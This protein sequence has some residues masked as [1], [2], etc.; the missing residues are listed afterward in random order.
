[1]L[2]VPVVDAN[3]KPLMPT[4]ANRAA[5]C[6]IAGCG[7]KCVAKGLCDTH[8]RRLRKHGS[9][10]PTRVVCALPNPSGLCLCGCGQLAPIAAKT[11]LKQQAIKGY[12]QRFVHGHRSRLPQSRNKFAKRN[13]LARTHGMRATPEYQAWSQAKDRCTN[14]RSHAWEN[15]GGRGIKF[16]FDSFE[17][18]FAELGPRPEGVD[19][20]GQA[21]Y[22]VDRINNNGHYEPG[23][24]RWATSK[25]QAI[26]RRCTTLL[27]VRD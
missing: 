24:V 18:W 9:A 14:P 11:S 22:S 12:P 6:K 10:E 20:N 15:Y 8:Y 1:M 16:L 17:E 4:T 13:V 3:Q 26:N 7:V 19:K 2:F 23:N 5:S 27:Q 25:E 21:L